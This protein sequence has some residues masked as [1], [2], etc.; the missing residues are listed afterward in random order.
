MRPRS[1]QPEL[2]DFDLPG[3]APSRQKRSRETTLALLRA[4]AAMLRTRSLVELSI[5][6]LCT[7]VGATV[8]A[9]YSRFESKETYFNAL[10]ALAAR[11][12][13]QRLDEIRRPSPDASL[14][15]LCPII[16][17]GI[18]AWMRSHE[19]VLRA[20]LQHDDTRPDKWTPFK[21]L[22]QATTA[23]ATPLLLPAMGKGRK[24]AK[25]RAIAFGFQIVLGT[26]VNAILND[27]G[28]LQ[29]SSK[30]METRLASCLL[31]LLQ[32]EL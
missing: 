2:R 1:D 9:F 8:G 31:L 22:A 32:A 4:G 17:G 30:E 12:G 27:P 26:L 7:E 13:E 28:P 15:Q 18:I 25:S 14:D 6:A 16:V 20:A 29:L 19:G 5:E 21:A 23:R 3:V 11:D 10:M 24:A